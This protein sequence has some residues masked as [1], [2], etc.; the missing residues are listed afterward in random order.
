M[1][2]EHG[3]PRSSPFGKAS[4]KV[5]LGGCRVKDSGR[6]ECHSVMEWIKVAF[7]QHYFT[8]KRADFRLISH[9]KRT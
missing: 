7:L 1:Q 6:S 3:K 2:A 8:R 4:R 9:H 5:S